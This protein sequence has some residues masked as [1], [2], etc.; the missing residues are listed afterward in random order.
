M[1]NIIVITLIIC[2]NEGMASSLVPGASDLPPIF[3]FFK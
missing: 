2:V 3:L 1:I